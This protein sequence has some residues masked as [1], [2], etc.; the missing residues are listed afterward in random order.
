MCHLNARSTRNKFSDLE[1]LIA[2]ENFDIIAITESR[3]NTKDRDFLA[4]YNLPGYSIFSCDRENWAGGGVI[5][6]INNNLYP[7]AIQTEK[8]NN[9]DLN[10]V[11]L[12]SHNNKV[13]VC[14][15]YRP[16]G[17]SP[18][19]DN[20]LF[21]VVT[22]TCGHFETTVMRDF[23]LPVTRRGDTI[24]SHSG[25]KL[26]NNIL[27]SEL[28]QH[29][30][31]PTRDN[32]ILDLVVSTCEDL[33]TDLKVGLEFSTSDH[34]LITFKV[35]MKKKVFSRSNEKVPDFRRADFVKFR[36]LLS[37]SD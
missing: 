18:E 25:H 33:I 23:N 17:Q 29:V 2:T 19:T 21:D 12:R 1:E 4:E 27:E 36:N 20:K 16:P 7:C 10:F 31:S 13:I 30:N 9:G 32:N 15:I 28:H 24:R 8:I 5:L 34:R 14:L 3:L 35:K 6:Y 37:N 22:E 26:Y 11:E